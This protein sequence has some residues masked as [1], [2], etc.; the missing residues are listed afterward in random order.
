[1]ALTISDTLKEALV[2]QIG[3]E[4]AN[5][6]LYMRIAAFL[7]DKNLKNL[8]KHFEGQIDEEQHHSR[9]IYDLLVSLGED[10]YIPE[11][12]AVALDFETFLELAR[13]YVRKEE[14]TTASLKEIKN[15]AVQDTMPGSGAVVAKMIEM[16]GY[17]INELDE[18]T[19]LL[20]TATLLNEWWQVAIYDAGLK[21]D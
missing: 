6:N 8:A 20:D 1:M 3:A 18:S 17:Q 12:P 14:D 16:L 9:L 5:A 19:S 21:N 15:I 2:Q 7:Q 11:I 13:L 4:L 10:F